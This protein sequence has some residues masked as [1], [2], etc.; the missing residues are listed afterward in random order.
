M[1]KIAS[2][3][4]LQAELRGLMEFVHNSGK[5]DRKVLAAKIRELADRVA[6]DAPEVL[7]A[8]DYDL[9][10]RRSAYSIAKTLAKGDDTTSA[11]TKKLAQAY[12]SV[13]DKSRPEVE[14]AKAAWDLWDQL[15]A[16][17]AWAESHAKVMGQWVDLFKK[18][19][20]EHSHAP[21]PPTPEM[22][23]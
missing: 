14:R 23:Q 10:L 8:Q 13:V 5:P 3:C 11:L 21:W 6:L 9:D 12:L 4:E 16:E 17:K 19:E 2:P 20:K 1:K 18:V 7:A 15:K 22:P